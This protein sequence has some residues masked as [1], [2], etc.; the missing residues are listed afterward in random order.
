MALLVPGLLAILAQAQSFD[1]QLTSAPSADDFLR[2]W[3]P[4]ATVLGNYLYLD[5]GE[6]SQTVDGTNL[7]YRQSNQVNDTLSINLAESWD[8]KDVALRKI[9]KPA[10]NLVRQAIFTD[11][12]GGAFYAWGGKTSYQDET[13]EAELWKFTPG[14]QG[15]GS[16]TSSTPN[17]GGI[18]SGLQRSSDGAYASTPNAAFHFGG[19]ASIRSTTT[20]PFGPVPGYVKFNSTTQAWSNH[21]EGGWARSRL[22]EGGSAVYVPTF[23]PNGVVMIIGGREPD[24]NYLS[25]QNVTFM[26]PVTGDWHFQETETGETVPHSRVHHCV[27]GVESPNKTFEIFV[28]GGHL[29]GNDIVYDDVHVLSLPGFFWRK[30]D[31]ESKSPRDSHACVVAGDGKRQMISYGGVNDKSSSSGFWREKD[32]FPQGLGVFDMTEMAWKTRYEADAAAYESPEAVK[33]WYAEGGMKN[34][35]WSSDAVK[36]LFA[37]D[38]SSTGGS[39]EG[40]GGDGGGSEAESSSGGTST[41]VIAGGVVGGV[42]G[43]ALIGGLIWFL[44]RRRRKATDHGMDETEAFKM[45]PTELHGYASTRAEVDGTQQKPMELMGSGGMYTDAVELDVGGPGQQPRYH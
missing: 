16:W 19:V 42:L 3:V 31:Y 34:R 43:V 29:G 27:V 39:T 30:A 9:L 45:Q 13:P 36:Q 28:Y 22:L 32:P 24:G 17:D 5:G 25:M 2:K 44:L 38:E 15:D 33:S 26:D 7:K 37:Q 8:P 40:E 12:S 4:R 6:V 18:F 11:E 10:Q 41:A 21:T 1:S 14:S 35:E 23:G 20:R